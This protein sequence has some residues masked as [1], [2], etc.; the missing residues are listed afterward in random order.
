MQN[1]ICT[2]HYSRTLQLRP[3]DSKWFD[4]WKKLLKQ[5]SSMIELFFKNLKKAVLDLQNEDLDG[6]QLFNH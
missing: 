3:P 1:Y 6:I 5:G 4:L 2:F